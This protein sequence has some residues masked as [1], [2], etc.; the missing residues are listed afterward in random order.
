MP[1]VPRGH[2]SPPAG[3]QRRLASVY[4][5]DVHRGVAP[6]AGFWTWS[7]RRSPFKFGELAAHPPNEDI[8]DSAQHSAKRLAIEA[9]QAQRQAK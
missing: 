9:K 5:P 2:S 3:R 6:L 4:P 8:P 1:P 7:R